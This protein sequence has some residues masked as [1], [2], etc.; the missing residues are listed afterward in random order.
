[1]YTRRFHDAF[2]EVA[3]EENVTLLPFLLNGVAGVGKLNQR[4]G[5]H[6]NPEGA[7]LV[8]KNVWE[9]VLPLVQGYR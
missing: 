5:I 2:E 4:D 3:K 9:G 8:A 7:K 1:T 6:P